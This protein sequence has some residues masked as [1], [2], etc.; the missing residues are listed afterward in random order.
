MPT[1]HLKRP[2]SSAADN[3]RGSLF[4]ALAMAGYGF[5]D[6]VIKHL[7]DSLFLG[8]VILIR[9]LF[10]T[11][12]ILVLAK[13]TGKLRP[14]KTAAKPA[15]L[16]RSFGEVMATVMFLIALFEI[17]IANTTAI[18]QA[19]PLS[20][21]LGAA[22]LFGEQI[23]VRRMIAIGVGFIGVLIIVRPGMEGFTIYSVAVLAAV[24][25]ATIRDLS[26]RFI[27][28]DVPALFI[29]LVTSV[30]VTIMGG[31][32]STLQPWQP[33]DI[34]MLLWLA[35]AAGVLMVGY[36]GI[37]AAMRVGDVGVIVPFR[38]TI[39]LYAIV[40]GIV[41]F[42]EIPDWQTLL[43]AS[44]IVGTGIYTIYRERLKKS[45]KT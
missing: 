27:D 3:M 23:G 19:L 44:I 12:F 43:G 18:I 31:A 20:V 37:A 15:V 38:Y 33:V 17:P 10:A 36:T 1:N 32:I 9:G 29:A 14:I 35:G 22:L 41:F 40:S 28:K 24:V 16:I 26:T 11:F 34:T 25:F 8:Q 30:L 5:N 2:A 45:D 7:S 39:L 42:D 13:L 21:A 4:M 6:I